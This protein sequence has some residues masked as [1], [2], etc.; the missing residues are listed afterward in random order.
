MEQVFLVGEEAKEIQEGAVS[1][2]APAAKF[3]LVATA[4]DVVGHLAPYLKG[5]IVILFKGS[6]GIHL[7]KAVE[8]LVRPD[9]PA[10]AH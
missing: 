3:L 10:K 6:R 8:L 5:G 7:D 2:G 1:A 4:E 9:V